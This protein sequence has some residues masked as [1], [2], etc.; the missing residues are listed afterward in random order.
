MSNFYDLI[1]LTMKTN[2]LLASVNN[3]TSLT[4]IAY[5]YVE[6]NNEK[7]KFKIFIYLI[8]YGLNDI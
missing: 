6:K 8:T 4:I 5:C 3:T 2:S 7:I 1:E